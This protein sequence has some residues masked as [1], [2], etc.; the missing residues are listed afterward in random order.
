MPAFKELAEFD[1]DKK[2]ML[3]MVYDSFPSA[4]GENGFKLLAS[5]LDYNPDTRIT[6]DEALVHHYFA[7]KPNPGK[8]SFVCPP[9]KAPWVKYPMRKV[10]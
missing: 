1:R 6:A 4:K 7:D 8:N 9:N 10:L 2:T 5:M 3:R